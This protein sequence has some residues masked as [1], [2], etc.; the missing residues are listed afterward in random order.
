M[1]V[2]TIRLKNQSVK[3]QAYRVTSDESYILESEQKFLV[4]PVLEPGSSHDIFI[5][6]EFYVWASYENSPV[7]FLQVD[8]GEAVELQAI[9]RRVSIQKTGAEPEVG[10]FSISIDS[11][12]LEYGRFGLG[13]KTSSSATLHKITEAEATEVATYSI[14]PKPVF[15]VTVNTGDEDGDEPPN[16]GPNP[17]ST[18]VDFQDSPGPIT[19]VHGIDGVV[20]TL[21]IEYTMMMEEVGEEIDLLEDEAEQWPGLDAVTT[22]SGQRDSERMAA[23]SSPRLVS[24]SMLPENN[25]TYWFN[26]AF[27]VSDSVTGR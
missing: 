20:E 6:K 1:G 2:Y 3:P 5:Y 7:V 8:V 11:G 9:N 23:K 17:P 16:D 21:L 25:G 15:E 4:T 19:I 14:E 13:I 18:I 27:V 24:Q 10:C 12:F 22:Q 26:R